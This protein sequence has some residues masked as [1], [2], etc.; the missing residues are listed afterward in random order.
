MYVYLY[1][2]LNTIVIIFIIVLLKPKC[3][4][5][6]KGLQDNAEQSQDHQLDGKYRKPYSAVAKY[7][8]IHF[9]STFLFQMYYFIMQQMEYFFTQMVR[10]V[11]GLWKSGKCKQPSCGFFKD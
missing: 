8:Y 2:C 6:Y 3:R 1:I 4:D 9:S 10:R 11:L 7:Q 5:S